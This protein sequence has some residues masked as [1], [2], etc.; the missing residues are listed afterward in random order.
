MSYLYTYTMCLHVLMC[1]FRSFRSRYQVGSRP[2]KRLNEGNACAGSKGRE[3]KR[4]RRI[5]RSWCRSDLSKREQ[6]EKPRVSNSSTGQSISCALHG[7][8]S[9][10]SRT[11]HCAV[12]ICFSICISGAAPRG[13]CGSLNLRRN[14]Q[15]GS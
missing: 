15:E 3:L 12:H 7:S 4:I 5:F 8:L 11:T 10:S 2:C 14:I 1:C 6:K 9:E 13:T